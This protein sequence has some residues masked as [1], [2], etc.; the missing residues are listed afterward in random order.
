M[1]APV[2]RGTYAVPTSPIS[3][4]IEV[5]VFPQWYKQ[6]SLEWTIPP[7][8]GACTFHVYFWPGGDS[9]YERLTTNALTTPFFR[10]PTSREYS[11]FHNGYYVV[12][13]LVAS[14]AQIKRSAPA[15]WH[16]KRR[17]KLEIMASEIQRREYM[18]L[19]KFAGVK[20]FLFRRKL[21]GLRCHRCWSTVTEKVTDDHCPVC[22]GTSFEGGYFDPI[23]VFVQYDPTPNEKTRSYFGTFEAN[24]IG[25]WTISIPEVSPDDILIRTGDWNVYRVVR[26]ATTEIQANSVRQMMTLT[27]LSKGDVE[28]LLAGKAQE[29]AATDY[30]K[31]LGGSYSAQRF[32]TNQ[33]DTNLKN[34]PDWQ[35][36]DPQVPVKYR[37]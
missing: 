2:V 31:E 10:D 17:E 24:Q 28:N 27:Q 11:K 18:L 14:P 15:S 36:S 6:V 33:L 21:Y 32:P 8:W 35:P 25:G 26:V 7:D 4:D 1:R 9:G 23:P 5:T 29:P 19:S 13:V 37:I 30:L 16:P 20:T 34:N 22:L 12:E 3:K